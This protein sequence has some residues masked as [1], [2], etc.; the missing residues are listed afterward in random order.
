MKGDV[1]TVGLVV[2]GVMLAGLLMYHM[3]DIE[4]VRQAH[5][6]FDSGIV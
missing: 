4:L 1:K 3:K 2:L 5:G 6:G